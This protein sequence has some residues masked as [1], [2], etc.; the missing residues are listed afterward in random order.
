M[1]YKAIVY[2]QEGQIHIKL[3]V[4]RWVIDEMEGRVFTI[5]SSHIV[6]GST[7]FDISSITLQAGQP[8]TINPNFT[9][10]TPDD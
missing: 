10:E 2:Y 6:V 4:P 7:K 3:V 8:V 9:M 1:E 5:V